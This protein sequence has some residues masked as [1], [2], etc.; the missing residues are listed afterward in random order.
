MSNPPGLLPS[1]CRPAGRPHMAT[2]NGSERSVVGG[3]ARGWGDPSTFQ[4][5]PHGLGPFGT[6]GLPPF[7]VT[8]SLLSIG[9]QDFIG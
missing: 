9:P 6:P 3:P 4:I 8:D 5:S 2:Q 7:F 1:L